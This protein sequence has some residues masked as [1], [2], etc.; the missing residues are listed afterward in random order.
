MESQPLSWAR[1][2][3]IMSA[4]VFGDVVPGQFLPVRPLRQ[5]SWLRCADNRRSSSWPHHFP[6]T[7]VATPFPIRANAIPQMPA[8]YF[9]PRLNLFAAQPQHDIDTGRRL[10]RLHHFNVGTALADIR[11]LPTTRGKF[12]ST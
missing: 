12:S 7:S 8:H 4:L 3:G 1:A 5:P 6:T 2:T 9:G 11:D 10:Q